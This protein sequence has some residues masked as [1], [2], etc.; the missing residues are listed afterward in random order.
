MLHVVC[1]MLHAKN[2]NQILKPIS[3][4]ITQVMWVLIFNGLILVVLAA[5]VTWSTFFLQLL[6][7]LVIL[8]VAFS[9]FYGAYK[10]HSIKEI[11]KKL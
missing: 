2:M 7:G 10:M 8:V 4:K 3:G 9:F 5:L 1:Y 11:L 6:V